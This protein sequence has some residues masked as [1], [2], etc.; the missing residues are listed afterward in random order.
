MKTLMLTLA[1][2]V[3][4]ASVGLAQQTSFDRLPPNL[5]DVVPPS[6]RVS[7][8]P[9]DMTIHRA[10]CRSL[11]MAE[12]RRRIVDVAA[13]EWGFFGF[14]VVD[15]TSLGTTDLG[16]QRTRRRRRRLSPTESA[17]VAGSIAGYWTVTPQGSWII[18]EQN[19][20]WTG[21]RGISARWRYPWSAAFVSWVMCEGGLGDATQF[22]RAVAHHVYIDQAIRARTADAP[23]A[24]FAAYDIGQALIAPGDLLCS[25]RRPAY[26]SIAERRRQMG[27][28]A[29]THCDIVVK[30]DA[31]RNRI[32]AIGGNVRGSVSLKLLPAARE[33]GKD[34]R[35]VA[36]TRRMF[37]HLKLRAEPI[38]GDALDR[39]PTMQALGCANGFQASAR[40]AAASLVAASTN[41][42]RC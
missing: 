30:V 18:N 36:G 12:V 5:F 23:P 27:D 15:Q 21:P 22:Q 10:S 6:E 33:P 7:G 2:G 40:L 29:R 38:E 34:L 20:V 9:G 4:A 17:R 42:T 39:T 3:A 8:A 1:A 28:G 14:T 26:R 25:A 31:P 16:A 24:A 19:G 35:P 11:P 41:A 32:L 13:Q 37:A